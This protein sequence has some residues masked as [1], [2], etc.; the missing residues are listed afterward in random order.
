[1]T[2]ESVSSPYSP[3]GDPWEIVSASPEAEARIAAALADYRPL[4]SRYEGQL[5]AY[6]TVFET[7]A[8]F[9]VRLADARSSLE[10]ATSLY[11]SAASGAAGT[12]PIT[13]DHPAYN[14]W[15]L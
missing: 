5:A 8:A 14:G 15:R 7:G 2:F 1:V 9:S 6:H 3:G 13:G 12:M 11:H 10:L 4:P